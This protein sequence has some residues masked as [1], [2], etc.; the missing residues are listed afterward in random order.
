[1]PVRCVLL[2]VWAWLFLLPAGRGSAGADEPP[3]A[4]NPRVLLIVRDDCP[5]CDAELK[6]LAEPGGV[7]DSLRKQGWKIGPSA[8]NHIQIVQAGDVAPLIERWELRAFPAVLCV[9]RDE[10]VRSFRDGCS[11]PLDSFTFGWLLKGVNE[12]PRPAVPETVTVATSGHYP[13]RGNHWSFDGDWQPTHA[14]MVSH[15]RGPNHNQL[16]PAEWPIESWS[17]EELRSLHDDL[18]EQNRPMPL[19]TGAPGEN[20]YVARPAY[21][22]PASY[23]GTGRAAG[24]KRSNALARAAGSSGSSGSRFGR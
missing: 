9:D 5:A 3:A 4:R 11:T 6:R 1:M 15:L 8:G 2:L 20:V 22:P 7:F 16:F 14:T 12:R 17:D 21:V 24:P 10:I 13:L 23:S 18:H 19:L